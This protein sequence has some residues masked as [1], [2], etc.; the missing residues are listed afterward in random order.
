MANKEKN[1]NNTNTKLEKLVNEVIVRRRIEKKNY[2]EMQ[3]Q[4]QHQQHQ[5]QLQQQHHEFITLGVAP[6]TTLYRHSY[7]VYIT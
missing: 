6:Q 5:Q 7:Q 4:Q 3:L 2:G 1:E